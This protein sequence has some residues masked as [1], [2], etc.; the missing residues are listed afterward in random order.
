MNLEFE[1][2]QN[3]F[4]VKVM[5]IKKDNPFGL[6]AG[7]YLVADIPPSNWIKQINW[8]E[9][10]ANP[11]FLLNP[12]FDAWAQEINSHYGKDFGQFSLTLK[13]RSLNA[14]SGERIDIFKI[15]KG[16]VEGRQ[17]YFQPK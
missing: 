17:F 12:M 6:E 15:S 13:A 11:N 10:T 5:E 8:R 2:K 4:N 9:R 7:D 14:K 1:P 16:K 3:K